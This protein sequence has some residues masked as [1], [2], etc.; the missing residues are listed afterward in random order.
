MDIS[1]EFMRG[2]PRLLTVCL[3]GMFVAL[4]A[5][6]SVQSEGSAQAANKVVGPDESIQAAINSADPGDT[7]VVR[8][9]HREDVVIRKDGIKL[10]GDDAAIEAPARAKADSPC[11]K[12][13]GPEAICVLGDFNLETGEFTGPRVSDVSVSGFTVRGFDELALEAIGA[14]NATIAG[15]RAVGSGDTA[16]GTFLSVRTKILA[17]VT[18]GPGKAA[19]GSPE[20][21]NTLVS[22]NDL[23]GPTA[24]SG[25]V[26]VAVDP[27]FGGTTKPTN[28]SVI[29]NHFSRNKPDIIWD[30]S[31][32]GNHFVGNLC[33][34][35]VPSR[36][37]N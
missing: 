10:R 33:N 12:L 9:V 21:T 30:E 17:N 28:N 7:I 2:L 8:G 20:S 27:Y 18:R 5:V 11:S 36:L 6:S 16:I 34:T 25:G 15:N 31:G 35:S 29:G 3:L 37:C 14:S 32:S 13:F 1:L 26:V 23:S 4:I 19:I 22:G 24:V